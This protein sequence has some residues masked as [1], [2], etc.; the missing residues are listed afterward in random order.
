MRFGKERR[1]ITAKTT[2]INRQTFSL[3]HV[4]N[5]L[6]VITL[7]K[8]AILTHPPMCITLWPNRVIRLYKFEFGLLLVF[9]MQR[10]PFML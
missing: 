10:F 4:I 8:V 7:D 6:F 9:F 2:C 3:H 1:V 5:P